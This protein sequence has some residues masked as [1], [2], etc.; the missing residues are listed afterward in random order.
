MGKKTLWASLISLLIIFVF[1]E[2]TN[3]DL[4]IQKMLF[5]YAEKKWHFQDPTLLYKKIFY[6]GIKIPIYVIGLSALVALIISWKKKIWTSYRKG[7]II[8]ALTLILLPTLIAVVGKN[9]TDVQCPDD[10]NVFAGRIPYVKHFEAYP[11][12]PDSSDGKWPKG[13]CFPAGHA[14]GGFALLSL[15]CFFKSRRNKR[16]AF[17]V[18]MSMGWT[19][20]VFQMIRGNHFLSHH[21]VTMCLAFILVS[22]FNITIKDFND[23]SSQAKN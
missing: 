4:F 16:I 15:V 14:S 9:L 1:F 17:I 7:L 3:A 11:I 2:V 5:N 6:T 13:R 21:L 22:F 8:V 12:N 19:M 10:L 20:G 18:A 23:E